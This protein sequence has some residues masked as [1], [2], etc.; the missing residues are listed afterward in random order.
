MTTRNDTIAELK[1]KLRQ[2]RWAYYMK[3]ESIMTDAEYDAL[4]RRLAQIGWNTPT[5]DSPTQ[6]WAPGRSGSS[7]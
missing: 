5:P 7:P 6:R 3:N 2:A 1:E 4:E